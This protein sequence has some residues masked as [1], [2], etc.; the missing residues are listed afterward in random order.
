[1][2]IKY[3]SYKRK[4][5]VKKKKIKEFYN[6]IENSNHG[7]TMM[8]EK[9]QICL[10]NPVMCR[11]CGLSPKE[12]TSNVGNSP[13]KN[14]KPGGQ[15]ILNLY[16][17]QY[18]ISAFMLIK[19]II[20]EV[21]KNYTAKTVFLLQN[22]KNPENIFFGQSYLRRI[23]IGKQILTLISFFPI[24]DT[25]LIDPFHSENEETIKKI[26]PKMTKESKKKNKNN[27]KEKNKKEKERTIQKKTK[28]NSRHSG[29]LMEL[30]NFVNFGSQK[31]FQPSVV[32]LDSDSDTD[33]NNSPLNS[34]ENSNY[35]DDKENSYGSWVEPLTDFENEVQK[36]SLNQNQNLNNIQNNNIQNQDQMVFLTNDFVMSKLIELNNFN[37]ELV[38]NEPNSNPNGFKGGSFNNIKK[39]RK[40]KKSNKKNNNKPI[41]IKNSNKINKRNKTFNNFKNRKTKKRNKKNKTK[42]NQKNIKINNIIVNTNININNITNKTNNYK[43]NNINN[44]INKNI[45]N[46]NINNK[47][48]IK[49][50]RN[51]INDR[52]L[53]NP[54]INKNS[55]Y[56]NSIT[57]NN[58]TV[59]NTRNNDSLHINP[60][61]NKNITNYNKID[62]NSNNKIHANTNINKNNLNENAIFNDKNEIEN[63][64]IFNT[65]GTINNNIFKN[66]TTVGNTIYKFVINEDQKFETDLENILPCSKEIDGIFQDYE[67]ES[68]SSDSQLD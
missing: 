22:K 57:N 8:N 33:H 40:T 56:N 4:E 2:G 55:I 34:F 64:N 60:N 27:T 50:T 68:K 65:K 16:Q 53:T 63:T 15:G 19:A 10:Y 24:K 31:N 21:N 62:N 23:Q 13:V 59:E 61:N 52:I 17:P 51:N 41:N 67:S 28:K 30:G 6:L 45:T 42:S 14:N 47:S 29:C 39:N 66:S 26:K 54:K 48:T 20:E 58:N 25:P 49:N 9:N 3:S 44:T 38:P 36:N 1:M 7:I 18:K 11:L 35:T 46:I 32:E 5:I 43:I 37:S 12:I